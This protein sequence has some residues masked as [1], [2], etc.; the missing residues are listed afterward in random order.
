MIQKM[1]II[2]HKKIILIICYS[3]LLTKT[4]NVVFSGMWN[5]YLGVSKILS[6][7]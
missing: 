1:N 5:G 2:E 7:F 3:C 6:E 4:L